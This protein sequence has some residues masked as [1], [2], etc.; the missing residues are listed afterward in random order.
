ME[1]NNCVSHHHS[2]AAVSAAVKIS[3]NLFGDE[4]GIADVFLQLEQDLRLDIVFVV[5]GETLEEIG[6]AQ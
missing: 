3:T 4:I 6:V 2:V 5:V 1:S